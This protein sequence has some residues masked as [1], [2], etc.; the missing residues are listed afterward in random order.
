MHANKQWKEIA[1]LTASGT[2]I[3][4]DGVYKLGVFLLGGGEGG[5]SSDIDSPSSGKRTAFVRG[6]FSGWG[7]SVVLDVTPGQSFSTVIGAGG[8]PTDDYNTAP[9]GDTKFGS[10]VALGGGKLHH[11][12]Y[13]TQEIMNLDWDSFRYSEDN[14]TMQA[15]YG[16]VSGNVQSNTTA[17]DAGWRSLAAP[18]EKNIF[19]PSLKLFGIGGSILA[20]Q[21]SSDDVPDVFT[22]APADLGEMGSGGAAKVVNTTTS[23][24]IY[25][26][27]NATGY[28]NGGG[29]LLVEDRYN[30]EGHR[31]GSGSQGIIIVYA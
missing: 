31:G 5:L 27:N 28:G 24:V 11:G 22:V 1:R 10:Y 26:G 6:G 17:S 8:V 4:P 25:Y 15:A 19:D 18:D 23:G 13:G 21:G 30:L 9:G 29:A 16:G 20:S 7:L 12:G 2:Y 14:R 3:V